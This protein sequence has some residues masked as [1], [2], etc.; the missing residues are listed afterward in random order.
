MSLTVMM[1]ALGMSAQSA[2]S[3]TGP[4]MRFD[5]CLDQRVAAAKQQRQSS[6]EFRR[7]IRTACA[8]EARE[9]RNALVAYDKSTGQDSREAEQWADQDVN[10]HR[11]AAAR[12]YERD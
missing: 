6:E 7:S 12:R 9:F 8:A 3:V 10:D 11:D 5:E 2:D 1:I 4:R